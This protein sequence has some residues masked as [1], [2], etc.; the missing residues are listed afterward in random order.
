MDRATDQTETAFG[1]SNGPSEWENDLEEDI[2]EEGATHEKS[3]RNN[4]DESLLHGKTLDE[5]EDVVEEAHSPDKTNSARDDRDTTFQDVKPKIT[6]H[7]HE[8]SFRH[9]TSKIRHPNMDEHHEMK[10]ASAI[11]WN[12]SHNPGDKAEDKRHKVKKRKKAH[13]RS[14]G[15]DDSDTSK[16]SDTPVIVAAICAAIMAFVLIMTGLACL[17]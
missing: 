4:R 10:R 8:G 7:V 15:P 17:W 16:D 12:A 14:E 6:V 9:D 13:L 3:P 1:T 11:R 2:S 5:D